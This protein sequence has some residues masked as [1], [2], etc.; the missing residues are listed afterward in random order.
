M[1]HAVISTNEKCD[2]RRCDVR[3]VGSGIT[4]SISVTPF[5]LQIRTF[6][7]HLVAS[8]K[9]VRHSL[10]PSRSRT[11]TS[12]QTP[13]HNRWQLIED[14]KSQRRFT[15][16]TNL[17]METP[18]TFRADSAAPTAF[19]PPPRRSEKLWQRMRREGKLQSRLRHHAS[20]GISAMPTIQE[21]DHEEEPRGGGKYLLQT[22]TGSDYYTKNELHRDIFKKHRTPI[23]AHQR[24]CI[25]RPSSRPKPNVWKK[26]DEKST[27][28]LAELRKRHDQLQAYI[29]RTK[30]NMEKRSVWT[31]KEAEHKEL[32]ESVLRDLDV[33]R[34]GIDEME[35]A[36]D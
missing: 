29:E 12:C 32:E 2:T 16:T 30:W 8:R 25:R 11:L 35:L 5:C 23:S 22:S 19:Q 26:G 28:E 14:V 31:K 6:P 33:I 20:S 1:M 27:P 13:V 36:E 4:G 17:A 9:H 3:Y 24:H 10:L 18:H 34:E 15:S 7:I 21:E